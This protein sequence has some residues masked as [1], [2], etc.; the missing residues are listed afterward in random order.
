MN[1]KVIC[2]ICNEQ[3]EEKNKTCKNEKCKWDITY[4]K[5][6]AFIGL[7]ELEMTEYNKKLQQAK[8]NYKKNREGQY[9]STS[10]EKQTNEEFY[11]LKNLFKDEFE[12]TADFSNRLQSYG[13]IKIGT[14]KLLEYD[15]NRQIYKIEIVLEKRKTQNLEYEFNKL[16][17]LKITKENAK[18]LKE[19]A[20][21]YN[22]FA[23]LNYIDEKKYVIR[24][25]KFGGCDIE[26]EE[27]VFSGFLLIAI[28][29]G[30][31]WIGI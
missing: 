15:A 20:T 25:L 10:Y 4:S 21:E 11:E 28:I 3:N 5:N 7:S 16:T 30:L 12:T 14:Y 26:I 27:S 8:K 6:G 31:V 23:K 22:L 24:C 19:N 9:L 17:E 13:Y 29:I 1:E 2:P 18:K